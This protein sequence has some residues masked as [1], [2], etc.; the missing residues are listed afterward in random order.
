MTYAT[1]AAISAVVGIIGNAVVI[2]I[3][4][5]ERRQ[6]SACKLH[7]AQLAVVNFV[8][9]AVQ[10]ANVIPLYWTNTW[11]YG[12]PMCKVMKTTLEVG[13]LLSSGLVMMTTKR[14]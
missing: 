13:S 5:H 14:L 1:I 7:I 8:F 11:I 4:L 10:I 3:A 2:F 12:K 6:L 9:S